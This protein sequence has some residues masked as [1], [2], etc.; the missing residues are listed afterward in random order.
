[1]SVAAVVMRHLIVDAARR[2]ASHKR[3]GQFQEINLDEARVGVEQYIDEVI[4][5]D[6]AMSRLAEANQRLARVVE[7]RFFGGLSIEEVAELLDLTPR[8]V[9]RDWRK[10]R[11]FLRVQLGVEG[12]PA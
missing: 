3:G 7:L 8:T 2:R 6:T 10:A 9:N 5:V 4:A 1:M 12:R 11:A